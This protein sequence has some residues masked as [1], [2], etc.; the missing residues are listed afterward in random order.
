MSAHFDHGCLLYQQNRYADAERELKLAILEEPESGAEHAMLARVYIEMTRL[1]EAEI[2]AKEALR[3]APYES[4]PHLVMGRVL[5]ARGRYKEV[6]AFADEAMRIEPHLV[7]AWAL[8]AELAL[9]TNDLEAALYA[10]TAGFSYDPTDIACSGLRTIALTRLGRTA[11]AI[12]ESAGALARNPDDDFAHTNRGWALLHQGNARDA[13]PAFREA[14]RLDPASSFARDGMIEALKGQHWLYRQMLRYFL[15]L[16]RQRGWVQI[17][18]PLLIVLFQRINDWAAT[19]F[20]ALRPVFL[21]LF[22]LACLFGILSFV[23]I[24]L[25]NF[26]LMTSRFGRQVLT[27]KEKWHAVTITALLVA[28]I[29]CFAISCCFEPYASLFWFKLTLILIV[30]L[31]GLDAV[32]DYGGWVRVGLLVLL[33]AMLVLSVISLMDAADII[34]L[35]TRAMMK[36]RAEELANLQNQGKTTTKEALAEMVY[37]IEATHRVVASDLW[38]QRAR[39]VGLAV[40]LVS[41]AAIFIPDRW[42]TFGH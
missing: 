37:M 4:Y 28:G 16:G 35:P 21:A 27:R 17:G 11:E 9:L 41:L 12:D 31:V 42:K 13:L 40:L 8:K 18:V 3:L 33:A 32:F 7:P 15:W 2:E 1:D 25:F 14:L 19:E 10:A 39:Y 20:P 36:A 6:E 5:L 26:I 29:V 22:A 34:G 38:F 23:A 24:P 30:F